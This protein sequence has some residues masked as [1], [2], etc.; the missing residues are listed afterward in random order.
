MKLQPAV[1]LSVVFLCIDH[2]YAQISISPDVREFTGDGGGGYI[3]TTGSGGWIAT[4][5]DNWIKISPRTNGVAEQ[6]CIYVVR[7]NPSIDGRDGAVML[8]GI[9]HKVI[10]HGSVATSTDSPP[11]PPL[12]V[13][14]P[15]P[16]STESK[17]ET[18]QG[19]KALKETLD[20]FDDGKPSKPR[21]DATN[22]TAWAT[23]Q[24]P[25]IS[26]R[27]ILEPVETGLKI[28]LGM[29]FRWGDCNLTE[30]GQYTAANGAKSYYRDP[31][32][33]LSSTQRVAAVLL[34][35]EYTPTK[36]WS[37]GGQVVKN[38][39]SDAGES[40]SSTWGDFYRAGYPGARS[41]TLD[42]KTVS[43]T[44][45]DLLNADVYSTYS[46]ISYDVLQIG[47]RLGFN[48]QSY[49]SE[50][51]NGRISF[52]S[53][54]SVNPPRYISGVWYRD[55]WTYSYPYIQ[56]VG[57]IRFSDNFTMKCGLGGSPFA[58]YKSSATQ[59]QEAI[60]SEREMDGTAIIGFAEASYKF[61]NDWYFTGT[62]EFMGGKADG[63]EKAY[64]G[65]T[66]IGSWD[67]EMEMSHGLLS[68]S[69]GKRL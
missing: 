24:E 3:L 2:T 31:S 36:K 46:F 5:D 7:K 37:F 27:L 47:L 14:S 45:F 10:Q 59:T 28:S 9:K 19:T 42:T 21:S 6:P 15:K 20:K 43:D 49:E 55:E 41:Y 1:F 4:T 26:P 29:G 68:L 53:S 58:S 11:P 12:N 32:G 60:K 44:E 57:G 35:M 65:G 67:S 63:Q 34:N 23:T 39:T 61:G 54:W 17:P 8:N 30:G 52:P 51:S 38:I 66:Y 18:I 56:L 33:E 64:N 13:E 40:T 69:I 62:V 16:L 25:V 50:L 22:P 48:Y